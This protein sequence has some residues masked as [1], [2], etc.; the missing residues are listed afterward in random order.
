[1]AAVRITYDVRADAAFI[2]VVD[3]IHDGEVT[4]SQMCDLEL[5]EGAVIILFDAGYRL[6]GFEI[7]GASRL[8]PREILATA[9]EL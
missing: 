2:Y 4:H 3:K 1:M 8:V 7:L 5:R 9:D 6:L